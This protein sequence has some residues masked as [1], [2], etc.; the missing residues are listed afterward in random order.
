MSLVSFEKAAELLLSMNNIIILCHANPDGDTLGS[1]FALC[2][3]LKALG[4]RAR[5]DCSCEIPRKFSYL[6][7]C[8]FNESFEAENFVAVDVADIK[9]LGDEYAKKYENKIKLN[10]DHHGSTTM[11]AENT[12]LDS[13]AAAAC[14]VVYELLAHLGV[15]ANKAIADCIYTGISTDTGCFRFTNTTAKTHI[16]ASKVMEK[17]ADI[18][19][20]NRLMF[21]TK[22]REYM[23]LEKLALDTLKMYF[24]GRCAVLTIMQDMYEKSGAKESDTDAICAIP[25][26]IEG[27]QIG[28]S[29]KQK[30]ENRFKV[31]LRTHAPYDAAKIC[32]A[33][34]GGGH[35]RAAGCEIFGSLDDVLD[36]LLKNIEAS[37]ED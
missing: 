24:D 35:P 12:L 19:K 30:A 15:E 25:R 32:A 11:F 10:I 13:S 27:V 29:I 9:L 6:T 2:R 7:D 8:V 37:L 18:E 4:K 31:S 16:I 1:G 3:A 5:V 22:S 28:A 26:Q 34:G 14:E 33:M 36:E 23:R 21:E 17:G 20:I